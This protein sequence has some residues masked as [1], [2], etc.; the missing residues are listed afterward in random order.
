MR[1]VL[2]QYCGTYYCTDCEAFCY[3]R[4]NSFAECS[5]DCEAVCRSSRVAIRYADYSPNK[6][7]HCETNGQAFDSASRQP[8]ER[9]GD[10]FLGN[11][12]AAPLVVNHLFLLYCY[13]A[14]AVFIQL[15]R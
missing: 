11:C 5:T 7:S 10:A 1:V 14:C 13:P 3:T 4:R 8:D 6:G 12:A 15:L 9:T 2:R